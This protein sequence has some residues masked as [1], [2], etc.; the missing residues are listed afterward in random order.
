LAT[1]TVLELSMKHLTDEP[2]GETSQK[3]QQRDNTFHVSVVD[4]PMTGSSAAQQHLRDRP[5]SDAGGSGKLSMSP[6]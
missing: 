3:Q 4:A 1:L 6:S 5:S 2:T